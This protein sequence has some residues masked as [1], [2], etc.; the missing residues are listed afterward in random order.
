VLIEG[1]LKQEEWDD[2]QTGEKKRAT[3]IGI[4]RLTP[5]DWDGDGGSA[6]GQSRSQTA[7][8]AHQ[9]TSARQAGQQR[10]IE[11]PVPEDDIP[12]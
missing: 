9:R 5:L 8:A 4:N 10:H 11:E 12:F 7:Q 3:R 2:R 6:G 1:R